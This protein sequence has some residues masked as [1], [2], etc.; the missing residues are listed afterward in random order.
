M[1]V[2]TQFTVGEIFD[3]G[4]SYGGRAYTDCKRAAAGRHVPIRVVHRGGHWTTDDGVSL[5][6]L[7]PTDV[8]LVD[9][10]DDVNENSIVACLTYEQNGAP[11]TALFMGDAGIARL[12]R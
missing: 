2:V 6:I 5:D 11:F 10:G 4:Q 9:T 3:S 1:G 7:A 8:P 12:S